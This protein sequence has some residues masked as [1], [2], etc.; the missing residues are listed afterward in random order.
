MS[1][2]LVTPQSLVDNCFG[3]QRV[4]T[5]TTTGYMFVESL[6]SPHYLEYLAWV[7]EG[8]TP[9]ESTFIEWTAD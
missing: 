9:E 7:Q 3:C 4:I 1:R 8:N 2:Y 6:E 5:D